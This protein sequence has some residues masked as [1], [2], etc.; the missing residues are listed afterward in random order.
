[1]A[2]FAFGLIAADLTEKTGSLGAAIGLHFI[3]NFFGLLIISIP[4]T[5]TGLALWVTPFGL[6]DHG[7]IAAS[8]VLNVVFLVVVWRVVLWALDY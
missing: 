5:I 7:I 3:N 2:P 6:E 1:V 8:L 4:G